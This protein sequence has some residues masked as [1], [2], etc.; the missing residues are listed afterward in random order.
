[1]ARTAV[2]GALYNVKVNLAS[3]RDEA[4]V[5]DMRA[6]CRSLQD[7]VEREEAEIRALAPELA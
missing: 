7:R 1:M 6:K 5:S 3:I 4:Y 2:L